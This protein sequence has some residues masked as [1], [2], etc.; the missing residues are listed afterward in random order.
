M[1]FYSP[2]C[3]LVETS[4]GERTLRNNKNMVERNKWKSNGLEKNPNRININLLL[5]AVETVTG[6]RECRCM[7]RDFVMPVKNGHDTY[8][9][10]CLPHTIRPTPHVI[11]DDHLFGIFCVQETI[12]RCVFFTSF[13]PRDFASK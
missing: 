11:A 2:V 3:V 4:V 10:S 5:I 6:Q 12:F 9:L 13:R 1:D 8:T 7:M